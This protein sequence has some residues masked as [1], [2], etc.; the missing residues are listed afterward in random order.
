MNNE[1][2]VQAEMNVEQ[3]MIANIVSMQR[4]NFAITHTDMGDMVYEWVDAQVSNLSSVRLAEILR[5]AEHELVEDSQYIKAVK[6]ELIDRNH[7]HRSRHW[8]NAIA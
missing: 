2:S 6:K 7:Y 1:Y 8:Q 4:S 3:S 5:Q